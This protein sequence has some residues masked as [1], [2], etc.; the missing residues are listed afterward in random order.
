MNCEMGSLLEMVFVHLF[1]RG[2]GAMVMPI[3]VFFT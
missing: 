1:S 3:I 2:K